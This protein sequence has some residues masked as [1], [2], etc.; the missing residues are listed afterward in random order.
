M[1]ENVNHVLILV[2]VFFSFPIFIVTPIAREKTW[3]EAMV[4][5]VLDRREVKDPDKAAVTLDTSPT[6]L[7]ECKIQCYI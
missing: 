6:S 1:Y 4:T 2:C 7:G 3:V 5:L